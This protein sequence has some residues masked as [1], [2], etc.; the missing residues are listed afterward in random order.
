M[1][2]RSRGSDSGEDSQRRNAE[3]VQRNAQQDRR[4]RRRVSNVVDSGCPAA[5]EAVPPINAA[6]EDRD[7]LS[8]VT[9]SI[10]IL[11][12]PNSSPEI[13]LKA[14]QD[15]HK[16]SNVSSSARSLVISTGCIAPLI[17]RLGAGFDNNDE[18]IL[19]VIS[20]LCQD[21]TDVREQF[22]TPAFIKKAVALAIPALGDLSSTR[23]TSKYARFILKSLSNDS[24][25]R[26]DKNVLQEQQERI[27][28]LK[29]EFLMSQTLSHL[30]SEPLLEGNCDDCSICLE[31]LSHDS[32]TGLSVPTASLT[33]HLPCNH[34]FHKS[35]IAKWLLKHSSCPVCRHKMQEPPRTPPILN[36]TLNLPFPLSLILGLGAFSGGGGGISF[37]F[38]SSMSPVGT[39]FVFVSFRSVNS[40]P[41]DAGPNDFMESID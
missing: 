17:L 15:I 7:A 8:T 27:D 28:G 29:V 9:S 24:N 5:Q 16:I 18:H 12:E 3:E 39:N 1:Q 41:R 32:V 2:R 37:G 13:V 14:L 35:C 23:P 40:Q 34:S 30:S 10:P 20:A 36:P 25:D 31:N 22:R 4:K 33:C 6:A 21:N 19:Q 26:Y 38:P 11:L